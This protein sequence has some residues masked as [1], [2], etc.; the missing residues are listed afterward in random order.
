METGARKSVSRLAMG[1]AMLEQLARKM[2]IAQL[3]LPVFMAAR[4]RTNVILR[5][6]VVHSMEVCSIPLMKMI[7]LLAQLRNPRC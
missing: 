5:A 4:A 1:H 3:A 6:K 2:V 7:V